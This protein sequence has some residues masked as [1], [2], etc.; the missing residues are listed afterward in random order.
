M[1]LFFYWL[2]R[3]SQMHLRVCITLAVV[4]ARVCSTVDRARFG[5][6]LSNDI[7]AF[8]SKHLSAILNFNV[9]KTFRFGFDK[10]QTNFL[11]QLAVWLIDFQDVLLLFRKHAF[12]EGWRKFKRFF[13]IH[14]RNGAPKNRSFWNSNQIK[15][16]IVTAFFVLISDIEFVVL[17]LCFVSCN[18]DSVLNTSLFYIFHVICQLTKEKT[19]EN[20]LISW[21]TDS[22][23]LSISS[24]SFDHFPRCKNPIGNQFSKLIQKR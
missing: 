3:Y 18:T 19:T 11:A 12:I 7:I 24:R 21:S 17:T 16:W 2:L 14:F 13:R 8:F 4:A 5:S 6:F 15:Y 20:N 10:K 23:L 1:L 22:V 9:E